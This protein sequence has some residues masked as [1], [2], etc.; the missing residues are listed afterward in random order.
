M[1]SI[2]ISNYNCIKEGKKQDS[3]L[4]RSHKLFLSE[5]WFEVVKIDCSIASIPLFRI[6]VPLSSES[7]QFGAKMTRTEFDNKI[8][9]REVLRLLYLSL[10]Q[11]LGSK[12][13]LKVFII[14]NNVNKKE[15]DFLDSVTKFWK[16]QK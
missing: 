14:Y 12:K 15:L 13:I 6:N 5:N 3:S 7:V 16:L 8:K 1:Q 2:K 4:Y 9:L 11:H 10:G